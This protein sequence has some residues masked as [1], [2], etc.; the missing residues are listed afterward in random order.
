M[1]KKKVHEPDIPNAVLKQAAEA[2]ALIARA[3]GNEPE[4][5]SAEEP[6]APLRPTH[7]DPADE[8]TD[9]LNVT[10]QDPQ[11][12]QPVDIGAEAIPTPDIPAT[13]GD[14]EHK[15]KVLQGKY[16][17][18]IGDLRSIVDRQTAQMANFQKVI[19]RQDAMINQSAQR[20]AV[21]ATPQLSAATKKI[22]MSTLE[23]YGDEFIQVA[24]A[25]NAQADVIAALSAKLE[26]GSQSSAAP[27][28]DFLQRF[29]RVE[30]IT[31]KSA[32]EKFYDDLAAGVPDWETINYDP[33][34]LAWCEQPDEMS[35]Y[36]R[37]QILRS[38]YDSLNADRA[39]AVFNRYK[40]ESGM[41]PA[42]N[43]GNQP[44]QARDR[45]ADLLVPNDAGS[46]GQGDGGSAALDKK[47]YA[48]REEFNRAKKLFT[49][50]KITEPEF[51]IISNKFQAA[52]AAGLV[53]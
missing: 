32:Q 31:V 48:T 12:A 5:A 40:A 44:A 15:F 6:E 35:G 37:I 27:N 8:P 43:K 1:P 29:Q 41:A 49:T 23:G 47:K 9:L 53:K 13:G 42:V 11:S 22:D 21:P 30:E 39:R 51:D 52:I 25:F 24:E 19:D 7:P 16:N 18:E 4:P 2:D 17:R 38:A 34:F 3:I 14:W 28:E 33:R 36:A 50:Q 26:G 46:D 10:V 20:P 45:K